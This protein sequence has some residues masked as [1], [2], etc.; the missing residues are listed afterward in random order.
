MEKD[1]GTDEGR[2]HRANLMRAG[3]ITPFDIAD[4]SKISTSHDRTFLS[5]QELVEQ[6]KSEFP[7]ARRDHVRQAQTREDPR[8]SD[9]VP[10]DRDQRTLLDVGTRAYERAVVGA[11]IQD[12]N[13]VTGRDARRKSE[14]GMK[15]RSADDRLTRGAEFTED[16]GATNV[17]NN[18]VEAVTVPGG[19]P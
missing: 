1:K 9:G 5:D 17:D 12:S 16:G 15:S 7:R 19:E 4:D 8:R 3:A 6:M 14:Q 13:S 18:T 11:R 2:Q 10:V